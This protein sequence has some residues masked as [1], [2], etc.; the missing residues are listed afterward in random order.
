LP[1]NE[2]S[3]LFSLEIPLPGGFSGIS[4]LELALDGSFNRY[5]FSNVEHEPLRPLLAFPR[6]LSGMFLS[7]NGQRDTFS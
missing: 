1:G 6:T 7:D 4:V 5:V 3:K 2:S